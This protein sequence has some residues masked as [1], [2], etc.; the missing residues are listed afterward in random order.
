MRKEEFRATQPTALEGGHRH[1][2]PVVSGHRFFHTQYS[3]FIGIDL[4]QKE[5]GSYRVNIQSFRNIGFSPIRGR[6]DRMKE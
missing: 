5:R 2:P 1:V 3:T 6:K 4:D